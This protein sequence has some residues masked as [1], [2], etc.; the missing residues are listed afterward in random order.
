[1]ATYLFAWNPKDWKWTDLPEVLEAIR[2][3]KAEVDR[4]SIGRYKK[5]TSGDRF[6]LIKLGVEPKGLIGSGHITSSYFEAPHYSN[7]SK[8]SNYVRI[9]F[10]SLVDGNREVV[11]SRRELDGPLFSGQHWDTESS[12]ISIKPEIAAQLEAVWSMRVSTA[13]VSHLATDALLIEIDEAAA[14]DD[15][16]EAA[17]IGRTD[18]GETTKRQLVRA[19]RGQGTFR[20]NVRLNE[21]GCR[22][23]GVADLEHLVASHIKPWRDSSDEEKLNGCNGLLLAPHI[24]H[25]FDKGMISFRDNGDLMLSPR[26]SASLLK[27]WGI[28]EKINVGPFNVEQAKFLWHHRIEVL[29]R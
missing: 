11:I 22:V 24:D 29:K 27:A 12:G 16:H 8:T 18:I 4:W 2:T 3:G 6:F 21:K 23:T 15:G 28:P 17:I 14:Q 5:P 1:M 19:R 10:D 13:S 20:S 26:L 25:L 9:E 7:P